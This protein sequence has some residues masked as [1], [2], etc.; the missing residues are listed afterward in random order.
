MCFLGKFLPTLFFKLI[1]TV[2]KQWCLSH[3]GRKADVKKTCAGCVNVC[4]EKLRG[5]KTNKLINSLLNVWPRH[6]VSRLLVASDPQS[7]DTLLDYLSEAG[8]NLYICHCLPQT[9][10]N[11]ARVKNKCREGQYP[12]MNN[13]PDIEFTFTF[14]VFWDWELRFVVWQSQRFSLHRL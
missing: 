6:I 5:V 13:S 3:A 2:I 14:F 7:W 10:S 9:L 1:Y 12:S 4:Q 8:K 11:I